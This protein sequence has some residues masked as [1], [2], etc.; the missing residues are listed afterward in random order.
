MPRIFEADLNFRYMSA[1][2]DQTV[3]AYSTGDARFGWRMTRNAEVSLV[4]QNLLQPYH[5]GHGG[6]P[7]PLIEIKR[8]FYAKIT[9]HAGL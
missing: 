4:G 8:S 7:G 9:F 6:N 1:V 5:A 3:A 2:P